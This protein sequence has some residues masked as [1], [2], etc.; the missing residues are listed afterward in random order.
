MMIKLVSA[1]EA[2]KIAASNF[3]KLVADQKKMVYEHISKEASAGKYAIKIPYAYIA[4]AWSTLEQE[5]SSLGYI[6]DVTQPI[7]MF[8]TAVSAKIVK[9]G[10]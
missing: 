8:S 10:W 4:D 3:N 9:I 5:L 7:D 6:V 1:S 2:R